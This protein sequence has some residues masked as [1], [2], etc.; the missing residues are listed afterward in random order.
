MNKKIMNGG[1]INRELILLKDVL[2]KNN[3]SRIHYSLNEYAEECV[4]LERVYSQKYIVYFA[5]RNQRTD[6]KQY[7]DIVS[8]GMDLIKR[9]G[10]NESVC[11]KIE[12]ELKA[13]I[14]KN[15][16]ANARKK[17]A[18]IKDINSLKKSSL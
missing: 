8:A 9:I 17:S 12:M 15:N 1:K 5:E 7:R 2:D 18:R 4:C 3:I 16:L 14:R 6:I 10:V 13:K 11:F